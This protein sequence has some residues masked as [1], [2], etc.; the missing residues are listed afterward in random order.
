MSLLITLCARGGSKGIPGK[1]IRPVNGVPLIA[2][3][4]RHAQ[5][6]AKK[7]GAD[8][9]LS[10]DSADIRAVAETFGLAIDYF[11]PAELATDSAGK[12]EVLRHLL[13][14]EEHRRGKRYEYLLDLDITSPL[15]TIEDL[16]RGFQRLQQDP[17]ALNL[18]SVSPARR[19]PYFNM[20]EE[21]KDGYVHLSKEPGDAFLCRQHAPKVYD[22]NASFYFYRR[23]FFE[24]GP[25]GVVTERSLCHVMP[26]ECFDLDDLGDFVYLEYLISQKRLDFSL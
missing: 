5:A 21:G 6:F 24:D 1:N 12:V 11:R 8:I 25:S 26:H 13:L 23:A 18:F 20:V 4:I 7:T 17:K 22:M 16:E 19:N 14:H 9:A 15:R 2:Y 10:T 3:S